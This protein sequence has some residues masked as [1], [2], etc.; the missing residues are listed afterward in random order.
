MASLGTLPLFLLSAQSVAIRRDLGFGPA[1]LGVTVSLF[2]GMAAAGVVF[3]SSFLERIGGRAST[4]LAS[5]LSVLINLGI[6]AA[7]TTVALMALVAMAGLVNAALQMTG[8]ILLATTV[9][10]DRRGLAFG[11]KQSAVPLSILLSGLAVPAVTATLG[12]RWPYLIAAGA[13]LGLV[14]I[15]ARVRHVRGAPIAGPRQRRT[16]PP[17]A[18][19]ITAAGACLAAA[20]ANSLGAF[21]PSWAFRSGLDMRTA[22]LLLAMGSAVSIVAR[23]AVGA[24]ADRRRGGH[25]RVV[26]AQLGL[27]A[28]GLGLLGGGTV[29]LLFAGTAVAFAIGWSWPGLLLFALARLA[30]RTPAAATGAVQAGAFTGGAFGPA[31]FGAVVASSG[32]RAAWA[33][34]AAS[35]VAAAIVL[36]WA[37]R[38]LVGSTTHEPTSRSQGGDG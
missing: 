28:V 35:M 16:A 18:L 19:L 32:Y 34:G 2:F 17:R 23:V 15:A 36:L 8:N 33:M 10:G 20:S 7:G 26:A 37:H 14:A 13:S 24:R 6:A 29:P 25:M 21:L 22:G 31:I 27:G 9:R 3:G 1:Q 12:W 38:S 11:V 30:P 5:S 4:L